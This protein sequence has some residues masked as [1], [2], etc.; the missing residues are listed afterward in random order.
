MHLQNIAAGKNALRL[1]L[2]VFIHPGAVGYGVHGN[3][4]GSCQLILR[5]K[6]DRQKQRIAGDI[7]LGFLQDAAVFVH[8][9][10][11]HPLHAL[12]AVD[13]GHGGGKVERNV[14][15]L[16]TLDDISFQA[17]GVGHKLTHGLYLGAL[18]RHPPRHDQA[19]IPGAKYDHPF[20][21]GIALAVHQLLCRA[22]AVYTG[23][24][25]AGGVQCPAAA[26]AA[27]HGQHNGFCLDFQQAAG[28]LC[29][30]GFVRRD[31]CDHRFTVG[32]YVARGDL[33]GVDGGIFRPGELTP[34]LVQAEAIV[35]ALLQDAAEVFLALEDAH[36][37]HT[38]VVCCHGCRHA[39]GAAADND[40]IMLYHAFFLTI[41]RLP[42]GSFRPFW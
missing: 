39:R 31:S 11:G 17:A 42:H 40:N 4:G 26:F 34:Q 20:A 35:D 1:G 15:I 23:R 14:E 18:Q 5:D 6:P 41:C 13:F 38:A 22:G 10:N 3:A 30:D 8:P 2:A 21:Y 28:A 16:Q 25:G 32:F 12:L 29:R 27:A 19:D 7:A 9:G 24:A 37:F 36:I 33:F